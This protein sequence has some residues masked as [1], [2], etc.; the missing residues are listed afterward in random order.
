MERKYR[1]TKKAIVVLAVV[2]VLFVALIAYL[3]VAIGSAKTDAEA[4]WAE[5]MEIKR[6]ELADKQAE[7]EAS[8]LEEKEDALKEQRN[9]LKSYQKDIVKAFEKGEDIQAVIDEYEGATEDAE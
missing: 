7:Y 4:Y 6:Q 5:Q 1:A 2:V 3:Q 8:G 9:D